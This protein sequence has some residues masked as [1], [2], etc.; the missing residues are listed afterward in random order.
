MM[1][2]NNDDDYDVDNDKDDN[3]DNNGGGAGQKRKHGT[4]VEA[5]EEMEVEEEKGGEAE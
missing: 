2:N 1:Y 3:K 4:I 5:W